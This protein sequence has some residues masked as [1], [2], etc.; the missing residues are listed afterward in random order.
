MNARRVVEQAIGE[1]MDG[2]P[3]EKSDTGKDPKAV[4]R[5]HEGGTGRFDEA[6]A[7]NTECPLGGVK[8][9]RRASVFEPRVNQDQSGEIFLGYG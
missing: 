1:Q 2:R 5:G 9:A 4:A 6:V 7:W 8:L 3:L